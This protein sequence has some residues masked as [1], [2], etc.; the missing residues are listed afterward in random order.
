[1][2]KTEASGK[3]LKE[4]Q[5]INRS[6]SALGDVVSALRRRASHVPFRNSK[7]TFLLKD[8]L[9]GSSKV[10]LLGRRLRCT[11]PDAVL[12]STPPSA[13]T[14]YHTTLVIFLLAGFDVRHRQL[15]ASAPVRE[16]LLLELRVP[17]PCGGAGQGET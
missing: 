16:H 15:R 11:T 9:T 8:S 5:H 6:L 12:A 1:M 14:R 4:A 10:R 7:L 13:N 3:M 2:F 17:V